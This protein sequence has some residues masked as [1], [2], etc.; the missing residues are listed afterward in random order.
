MPVEPGRNQSMNRTPHNRFQSILPLAGLLVIGMSAL[1]AEPLLAQSEE[2]G[3]RPTDNRQRPAMEDIRAKNTNNEIESPT[4][5]DTDGFSYDENY[6][7]LDLEGKRGLMERFQ[8]RLNLWT[9]YNYFNNGDLRV[10]NEENE[11]SITQTDD[12]IQFI[13]AGVQ[14]DTFLPVNKYLD[15][16]IDIWKTGFWGHDQLGG[17]D[18][19]NDSRETSSGS[20]TV[21]FG[22][23]FS[24]IHLVPE[25]SRFKKLDLKIGR[26]AYDIGGALQRDY[27]LNDKLDAIVLNWYHDYGR[28]DFLV[29]DVFSSGS[30]TDDVGFVQ[31]ISHDSEQV[32]GFNG[33]V[34]TYKQGM[35][36]RLPIY[37]DSDLGGTH[38][39]V[40]GFYYYAR[41]GGV[42]DG[43]S[44][45]TN[46]G[47]SGN[48]PDYDF[49][50]MRGGRLNLGWREWFSTSLTYAESFGLDRK[51]LNEVLLPLKDVDNNGKS[52]SLEFEFSFFDDRL[53]FTPSYFFADGGRYHMD[54][55]Q[56]S[57]GFVSMKGSQMGG[58]L[59]NLN[60][61]M[62]PSAYV[63]DDGID[64]TPYERNRKSGTE[65]QHLG[66]AIGILENLYLNLDWW[67]LTDTSSVSFLQDRPKAFGHIFGRSDNY[68]YVTQSILLQQLIAYFPEQSSVLTA[69]RRFGAPLGEEL[70]IGLEW[71]P[72]INWKIW[73]TAGVFYPMRYFATQGLVQGAPQGNAAFNGFQMGM[74]IRL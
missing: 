33:D 29:L 38:I 51:Q 36:Y 58:I 10:L 8:W 28:L 69:A 66:L 52:W 12:K 23:F 46:D 60:W 54:G 50:F 25:P 3:G 32:E 30:P 1:F 68:D 20:N 53:R 65:I 13:V 5:Y 18:N 17:R 40:R 43:G 6:F 21:A 26:Q 41:F 24:N 15:I 59:T 4:L 42:N 62:H 64:D 49:S 57:H 37:G 11:T 19:N 39:D 74:T 61:S 9:S 7:G 71:E 48:T 22:R 2:D 67:R 14:L 56:Y 27:Y 34:H 45:R 55:V 31:Y 70:N 73:A 47:T 72:R 35:T 16:R 44:D 63:D